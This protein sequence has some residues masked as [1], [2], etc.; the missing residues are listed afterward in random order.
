MF[1]AH[2][3]GIRKV[4]GISVLKFIQ[5]FNVEFIRFLL[6]GFLSTVGAYFLYALVLLLFES[7]IGYWFSAVLNY[8]LW[9]PMAYF[10]MRKYVFNSHQRKIY[11]FLRYFAVSSVSLILSLI[12]LPF[13]VEFMNISP[14][15]ASPITTFIVVIISY[16]GNRILVFKTS[17]F[18]SINK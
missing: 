12:L 10:L 16:F 5:K 9:L 6:V 8:F 2:S 11:G 15:A 17:A 3:S 4:F 7:K 1:S 18:L 13:F 14:L